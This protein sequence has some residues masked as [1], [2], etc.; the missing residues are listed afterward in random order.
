L[1]A[2]NTVQQAQT[3]QAT[4]WNVLCDS[5]YRFDYAFQVE[6]ATAPK[7]RAAAFKK[8]GGD[9]RAERPFRVTRA[10]VVA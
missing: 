10:G 7:A 3:E 5:G 1:N 6:A 9:H 8:F 2:P 4:L